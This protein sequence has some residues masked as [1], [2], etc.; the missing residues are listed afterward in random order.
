[1]NILEVCFLVN[2]FVLSGTVHYLKG[3]NSDGVCISTTFSISVS[4]AIFTVIL[5]Y[6]AHLQ[7]NKTMCFTLIKE[8]I[9]AKW[10]K[11]YHT[12]PADHEEDDTPPAHPAMRIPTTMVVELREELLSDQH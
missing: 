9:H 8:N 11:H 7:L 12:L 3:I 2:L 10:R 6:H 1:M 5:A 4:L